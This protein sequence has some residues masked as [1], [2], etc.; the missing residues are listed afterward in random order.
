MKAVVKLLK[1]IVD[2]KSSSAVAG[3]LGMTVEQLQAA[4]HQDAEFTTRISTEQ[5]IRIATYTATE[6]RAILDAQ[7]EDELVAAG[8]A[9][10]PRAKVTVTDRPAQSPSTRRSFSSPS[11]EF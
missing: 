5:A 6:P 10:K 9:V 2:S 3:A 4:T 1:K 11:S 7:T 8:V